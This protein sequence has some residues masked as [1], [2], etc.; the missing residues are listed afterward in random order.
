MSSVCAA[1]LGGSSSGC[2]S[3]SDASMSSDLSSDELRPGEFCREIYGPS[4]GQLRSETTSE[5]KTSDAGMD[6]WTFS[7][8]AGRA[9]GS[10]PHPEVGRDTLTSGPTCDEPSQIVDRNGSSSRTS[11]ELHGPWLSTTWTASGIGRLVV[12]TALRIWALP[13]EDRARFYWP[14]PTAKA[15]HWAPSMR[16][17][18][19][20]ARIQDEAPP[21]P[22]LFELMMGLPEGWISSGLPVR[23]SFRRWLRAHGRS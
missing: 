4:V 2:G 11:T 6:A 15:N 14:T 7:L 17:W 8:R 12:S 10:R 23:A 20:Y 1:G 5:L 16:K 19:A 21:T 9:R 3:R 22:A 18:P 13:I